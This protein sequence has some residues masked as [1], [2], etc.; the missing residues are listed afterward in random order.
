MSTKVNKADNGAG[1]GRQMSAI[2]SSSTEPIILRNFRFL[3]IS[4]ICYIGLQSSSRRDYFENTTKNE[5]E[6]P[7]NCRDDIETISLH[8]FDFIA[9]AQRQQVAFF[10][11][12][13]RNYW[14][15]VTYE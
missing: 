4:D 11:L 13:K 5:E 12:V 2:S 3:S 15:G 9:S 10:F 8:S 14:G 6:N 7:E 1:I